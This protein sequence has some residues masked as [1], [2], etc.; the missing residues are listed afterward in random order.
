[1]KHNKQNTMLMEECARCKYKAHLIGLGLGV[2][3]TH[4]DNQQ[5]KLKDDRHNMPVIISRVPS[6]CSLKETKKKEGLR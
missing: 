1:M 3:C 6:N 2:R 4:P 5:Y